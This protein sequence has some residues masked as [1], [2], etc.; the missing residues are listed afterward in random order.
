MEN[1]KKKVQHL[2]DVFNV[3]YDELKPYLLIY[4]VSFYGAAIS[5][6]S[7]NRLIYLFFIGECGFSLSR[8]YAIMK[9]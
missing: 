7:S 6:Y 2:R 1:L 4:L 9:K 5:Y 3:K 8:A